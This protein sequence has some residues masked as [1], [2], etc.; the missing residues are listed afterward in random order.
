MKKTLF[1]V[2]TL[3]SLA[4][5]SGRKDEIKNNEDLKMSSM[6]VIDINEAR[7]ITPTMEIQEEEMGDDFS[8]VA[9]Y[10]GG[11]IAGICIIDEVKDIG[12]PELGELYVDLIILQEKAD[13]WV[14]S[15]RSLE[16]LEEITDSIGRIK[17]EIEYR[18]LKIYSAIN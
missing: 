7:E 6:E 2:L 17:G 10:K 3:I 11:S 16:K 8:N 9:A 15:P 4:A 5:C 13:E 14:K 1:I 18:S 12:D